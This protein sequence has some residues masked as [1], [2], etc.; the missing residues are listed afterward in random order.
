MSDSLQDRQAQL[1]AIAREVA[2]CDKCPLHEQG[3][4]RT[5]PGAGPANADIMFIG[6]APGF[7]ED[8]KGLPFV[9]R[10]GQYLNY[11]LGTVGLSRTDVFIANVIKCRPPD[12]RDP[13]AGELAACKDYLDRQIA[14]IDP[15]III[16]LGRFSMAR[17]F[18][19]ARITKIHGQ[20]KRVEGRV[21][22]PMF[23][24]AAALRNPNLRPE[25][26]ADMQKVMAIIAQAEASDIPE[27]DTP[28]EADPPVQ[29]SLF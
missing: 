17:Y 16:T 18:P 22:F 27:D 28:P 29:L 8:R 13:Q 5:V 26:E 25:M 21:Y 7:N 6:E 15:K 10:S 2:V 4:T 23:H 11:L 9:G 24:P 20:P 14:V 1:A 3:R 19:G 12:N